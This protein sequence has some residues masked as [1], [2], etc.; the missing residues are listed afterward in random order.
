MNKK[1]FTLSRRFPEEIPV[2]PSSEAL[3]RKESSTPRIEMVAGQSC[4]S[5]LDEGFAV[6]NFLCVLSPNETAIFRLICLKMSI[7]EL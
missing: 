4:S 5:S 7:F 1:L 6:R 3:N 2:S